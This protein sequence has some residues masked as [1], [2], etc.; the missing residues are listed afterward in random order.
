MLQRF[1][2]I[3]ELP[4]LRPDPIQTDK[5]I[6]ELEV[7]IPIEVYWQIQ[8]IIKNMRFARVSDFSIDRYWR[9]FIRII[10]PYI[11]LEKDRL[12]FR[13]NVG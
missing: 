4:E 8:D 13:R 9:D 5:S 12:W 2:T 10:Y 7:I 6:P 1:L 3:A 11:L